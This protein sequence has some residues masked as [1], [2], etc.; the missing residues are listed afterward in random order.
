MREINNEKVAK[1][2]IGYDYATG[3]LKAYNL[4][5]TIIMGNAGSGVQNILNNV[6]LNL[7][8]NYSPQD[9][10]IQL[11]TTE[12]NNPWLNRNRKIPHFVN[13]SYPESLDELKIELTKCL[14]VLNSR[15][16]EDGTLIRR[17]NVI[18]VNTSRDM[19][20]NSGVKAAIELLA[21]CTNELPY[22]HLILVTDEYA[23]RLMDIE[24]CFELRILT[25]VSEEMSNKFLGC[26]LA[27]LEEE[28]YGFAWVTEASNFYTKKRLDIPSKPESYFSKVCKYLSNGSDPYYDVYRVQWE[29]YTKNDSNSDFFN[30]RVDAKH[31]NVTPIDDES[32]YLDRIAKY[33]E[34]RLCNEILRGMDEYARFS[35]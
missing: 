30:L 17:H 19:L 21:K 11:F 16:Y 4:N 33:D 26:N 22:A 18:I 15:E 12:K 2:M 20:D 24:R 28:K 10:C 6:L 3:D 9:V 32:E 5:N 25:R 1:V 29:T 8:Q 13:Q 14:R 27:S 34:S 35:Y 23:G 7:I 31:W